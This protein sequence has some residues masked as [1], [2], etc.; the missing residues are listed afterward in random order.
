MFVCNKFVTKVLKNGVNALYF[1]KSKLI[2]I[3][4]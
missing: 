3:E 4:F 2:L 1:H